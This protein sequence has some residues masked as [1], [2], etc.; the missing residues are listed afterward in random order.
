MKYSDFI[1]IRESKPAYNISN[2]EKGEWETFI[3]NAQFN[4]I[5]RRVISA[6][7][8]NDQD[9]HKSFW[10]DGTYG[11]GKSHAAAVI[12]HLLCDNVEDIREYVD[13]EYAAHRFDLLRQSIY[14]LRQTK[15]LFPVNLY[16]PEGISRKEDFSHRLQS[17]IKKALK[18]AGITSFYVKT[19][20]DD[21]ANHVES[22]PAFWEDIIA[23][24]PKLEAYTPDVKTLASKLRSA[25]TSILTQVKEA[26]AER[27]MDIR[28][29]SANICDWFFEIQD[30]L[31]ENTDFSGLLII[32]D[33][34]TDL[35]K[36]DIGPSL[37]VE[38]QNITERAMETCNNSYF[39]FISHP[40][41]LNKLDAQERTKTTGRYHYMK[42]NME[43]VSA[44][45]IMSRKFRI[46]NTEGYNTLTADFFNS[47]EGMLSRYAKDS[48]NVED[49]IKDLSNLFPIHPATANLATYYARVVGS[50]SRSVFEFIGANQAIRDFL[51]NN[52]K[53]AD[54]DTITAD[55]LWDYVLDVFN[56]D[57][58][59]YGAVTERFNSYKLQ[60]QNQGID[61]FAVFKGILLL[62]ALNNVAGNETVTPSEEN[63]KSLFEGTN[64]E[65]KIDQILDWFN[66]NSIIQRAP[67]GLFSIQFSALPPKE[68]EEIKLEMKAQ[69]KYTSQIVT[70]GQEVKKAFDM[71]TS[72]VSRP[73]SIN[74]Y[75]LYVNEAALLH[76]IETGLEKTQSYELFLAIM[77]GRNDNE[78]N[79]LKSIAS[80]ATNDERFTNVVFMVFDST[81]GDNNYERFIEYMA[82]AQCAA[83]HNLAD[84]RTAHD[85]NAQAMIADWMKDIRRGNFTVYV[86]GE[87]EMFSTMKL[88]TTLNGSISPLIFNC[89]AEALDLLRTRAP[90]TFWKNQQAKETAKNILMFNTLDE[91]LSK[92]TGPAM[93]LKFLFQDAVDDNLNWKDDVD[94]HHP[95]YLVYDFVNRKIKNADK[96]KEFNL[97]EKFIE[98][99]RPP[100]GLFPSY[101]GIAMLAFAMRPWTNK[102]YSTDGKPR[103][104]QH[105]VDDVIETFKAWENGK[106]S[107]KV[108][109]TF[110]TKEAGQLSKHLIKLFKL[111]SLKTYSDIS[112][113]K[114]ARWA[115][116]HEYTAEK[117]YPL[118]SLKYIPEVNEDLQS[119]IDNIVKISLD[120]N[121]NKNPAL[122]NETLELLNR[123]EFELPMLLNRN[124]AFKE[125]YYNF[126]KSDKDVALDDKHIEEAAIY[127]KQHL[128][129][130]V[131]L[132]SENEVNMQLLRWKASLTPKPTLTPQPIPH[133][134]YPSTVS[135]PTAGYNNTQDSLS[136]KMGEAMEHI[137][138]IDTLTQAQQI[139][140]ELC[141]LG[142]D[143]ILNII[144]K[145]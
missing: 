90:K 106:S 40:S 107:N 4:E 126:L 64:I 51:D 104:P 10:I 62:N 71:L 15:R 145:N 8:N 22:E 53:F 142:Y 58:L 143:D 1:T 105:L 54:H 27:R 65:Y 24:S 16:G 91:I 18:A 115:I 138:Q 94:K 61:T 6:V 14:D 30:K 98:L 123:Y 9:A 33:E 140:E 46:I 132:W 83:R 135:S 11:T 28:L 102:I 127:I 133:N 111:R 47:H 63:V 95:L 119:L 97:A 12:K 137:K 80:R 141:K 35:M 39:F 50:S 21:Y 42:Y 48:N 34:F 75:S 76:Q 113:L 25:D 52:E 37:L 87:V 23:Q 144:L 56:D 68:I 86:K 5:L 100:Y 19:D 117:G 109:F 2:E 116:S 13:V 110:E 93:P 99:T 122:M 96:T 108:T 118:W 29:D 36:S 74:Y 124:G 121:I 101:A 41:A 70:Y 7:R 84:Q 43:T 120:A 38:L 88:A 20:F 129:G 92:A 81:F 134:P 49:T 114:D 45:K 78:M 130:E 59:R 31:A 112:S 103:L 3:P 77:L 69:F 17:A 73:L 60:V 131:G 79:E 67:G 128:Q 125:G 85:K 57:H 32:W 136:L 139:L 89:G 82:N 66:D 44:F 55:Y 26:L 72:N